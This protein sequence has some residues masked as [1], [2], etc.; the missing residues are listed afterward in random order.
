M[1]TRNIIN[2]I[3]RFFVV[4]DSAIAVSNAV[5]ERRPVRDADLVKLGIDPA[6]FRTVD[7]R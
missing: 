3:G 7:Y 6:R 2:G 1:R 5:R 4:M